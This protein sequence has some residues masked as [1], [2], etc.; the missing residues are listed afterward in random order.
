MG[1]G[2]FTENRLTEN[3]FTETKPASFLGSKV[4][5]KIIFEKLKDLQK[6]SKITKLASKKVLSL[7]NRWGTAFFNI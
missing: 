4:R 2:H 1:L 5:Q 7:E 6:L 3:H